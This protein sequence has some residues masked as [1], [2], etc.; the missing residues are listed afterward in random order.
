[1]NEKLIKFTKFILD[2]MFFGGLLIFIT[3]PVS[4][5]LLGKYYSVA[6]YEYYF[7]MLAIFR[8]F[9]NYNYQPS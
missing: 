2:I 3:L 9:R 4:L 1:M 5:K 7:F 6:I 8:S